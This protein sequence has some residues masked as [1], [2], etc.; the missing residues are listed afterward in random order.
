MTHITSFQKAVA[1]NQSLL[2]RFDQYFRIYSPFMAIDSILVK[3]IRDRGWNAVA[4]GDFVR[5][6]AIGRS[7]TPVIDISVDCGDKEEMFSLLSKYV[8]KRISPGGVRIEYN[9]MVFNVYYVNETPELV[10]KDVCDRNLPKLCSNLLL[11]I[12]AIAVTLWPKKGSNIRNVYNYE[13]FWESH[14]KKVIGLCSIQQK[15][16]EDL[17]AKPLVMAKKLG[18]TLDHKVIQF[19]VASRK[20]DAEQ[21][22]AAQKKFTT[23]ELIPLSWFQFLLGQLPKNRKTESFQKRIVRELKPILCEESL[24]YLKSKIQKQLEK[25]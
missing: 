11:D 23:E 8:V 22:F 19:F 2:N 1:N 17:I 15:F 5:D 21:A 3:L 20:I 9:K 14:E 10:Q 25:V 18:Y 4:Y 13:R 16:P 12:D 6:L 24:K 7:L